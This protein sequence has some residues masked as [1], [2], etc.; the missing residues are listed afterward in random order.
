MDPCLANMVRDLDDENYLLLPKGWNKDQNLVILKFIAEQKGYEI[1]YAKSAVVNDLA[2]TFNEIE[3]AI[4]QV[5]NLDRENYSRAGRSQ[6]LFYARVIYCS[7]CRMNKISRNIVKSKINRSV[8][9]IRSCE[10]KHHDLFKF[11]TE[12]RIIFNNIMTIITN[13][14]ICHVEK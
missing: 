11:N 3:S 4:K 5:M 1:E 7:I 10:Q 2:I 8:D 12:Y 6:E 13:N 14:S 9:V